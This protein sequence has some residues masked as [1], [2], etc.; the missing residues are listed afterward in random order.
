M[1]ALIVTYMVYEFSISLAPSILESRN[2]APSDRSVGRRLV[3]P[4]RRFAS[5]SLEIVTQGDLTQTK[6]P[7]TLIEFPMSLQLP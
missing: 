1:I 5:D 2:W 6:L 7:R 4:R 3:P